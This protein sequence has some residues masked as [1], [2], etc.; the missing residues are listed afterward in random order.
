MPS[1]LPPNTAPSAPPQFSADGKW[2]WT[3]F[4]WVPAP[5]PPPPPVGQ[6]TAQPRTSAATSPGS[7]SDVVFGVAMSPAHPGNLVPDERVVC[8]ASIHWWSAYR[9][10]VLL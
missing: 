1:H 2:W 10:S 3:G 4:E 7:L 5:V 8:T 9:A 6:P